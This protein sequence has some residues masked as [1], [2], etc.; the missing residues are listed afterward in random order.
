MRG[1]VILQVPCDS[2]DSRASLVL[3]FFFFSSRRRHTRL[4]GDWSSDVCS[5]DLFGYGLSYTTFRYARLRTSSDTLAGDARLTVSVD[6]TNTGVRSG[7]EVVQLYVR[8]PHSGVARPKR[9]LR[10]FRRV[11]LAR[12]ETR[13]VTF[14]LTAQALRYWDPD[15]HRWTVENGPVVVEVGGSSAHIELEQ[16][17]TVTGQH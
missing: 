2:L 7:D 10:G 9:D 17:V 16:S 14:P 12:G 5:S 6:V 8:Y 13:T 3:L 11:T 15:G 4:Q 1:L